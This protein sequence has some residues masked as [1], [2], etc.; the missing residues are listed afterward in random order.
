MARYAPL[1]SG[2]M[3]TSIIGF[4][5]SVFFVVKIDL[6]WGFTFALFFVIAFV[7]SVVSMSKIEADDKYGLQELAI[8]EK[9]KKKK[10][11]NK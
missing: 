1:T 7:A 2:F 4:L 10:A 8:H 11:A 3:L 6:T 5:V 9:R